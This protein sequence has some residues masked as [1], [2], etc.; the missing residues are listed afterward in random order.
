MHYKCAITQ[1]LTSIITQRLGNVM[2]PFGEQNRL[3]SKAS[4]SPT[5]VVN[6]GLGDEA[7]EPPSRRS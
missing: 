3:G 1:G 7:D 4:P 5:H 2:Q 6:G